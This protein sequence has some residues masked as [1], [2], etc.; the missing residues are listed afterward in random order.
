M[1]PIT[2]RW[3]ECHEANFGGSGCTRSKGVQLSN[4]F[5]LDNGEVL[6]RPINFHGKVSRSIEIVFPKSAIPELIA[7][8]TMIGLMDG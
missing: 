6:I 4:A 8:L 7:A 3:P 1:D 5:Y 2:I